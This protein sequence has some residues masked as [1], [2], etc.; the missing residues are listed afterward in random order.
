MQFGRGEWVE[1]QMLLFFSNDYSMA[2]VDT[3]KNVERSFF[4]NGKT[5]NCAAFI[6][7]GELAPCEMTGHGCGKRGRAVQIAASELA[8]QGK[9]V[10][11]QNKVTAKVKIHFSLIPEMIWSDLIYLAWIWNGSGPWKHILSFFIEV[12]TSQRLGCV[13]DISQNCFSLCSEYLLMC[14]ITAMLVFVWPCSVLFVL[15]INYN[16]VKCNLRSPCE[17]IQ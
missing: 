7:S 1:S 15:A 2:G 9:C 14:M 3:Y 5:K 16:W 6:I 13:L 17:M 10:K 12:K 11:G 4:W 8:K